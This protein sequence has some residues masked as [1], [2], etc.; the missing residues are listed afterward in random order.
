MSTLLQLDALEI[1]L[2]RI[3]DELLLPLVVE[4]GHDA[5]HRVLEIVRMSAME[6]VER[7]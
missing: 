2:N 5:E 1:V 6:V 3:H 4:H 7:P